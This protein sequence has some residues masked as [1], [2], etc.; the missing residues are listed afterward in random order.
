[1]SWSQA[2][3]KLLVEARKRLAT[4]QAAQDRKERSMW[5]KAFQKNTADGADD[6]RSARAVFSPPP[7]LCVSLALSMFR[8]A[9]CTHP[10]SAPVFRKA[11]PP[12]NASASLY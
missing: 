2:A 11:S 9:V 4:V 12:V 5:S 3:Q 8:D 1:M 10:N 6:V 7:C